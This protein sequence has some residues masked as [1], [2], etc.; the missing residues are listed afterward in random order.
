MKFQCDDIKI[1]VTYFF[2]YSVFC[3]G[4]QYRESLLLAYIWLD[5]DLYVRCTLGGHLVMIRNDRLELL[6]PKEALT[7]FVHNMLNKQFFRHIIHFDHFRQEQ[8]AV[9]RVPY[10]VVLVTWL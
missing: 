8:A 7:T 1:I 9:M 2:G 10:R 6:T 4:F 5:I 3:H